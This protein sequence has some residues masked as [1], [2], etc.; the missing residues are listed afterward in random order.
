MCL[1]L[2][3]AKYLIGTAGIKNCVHI[4]LMLIM[5]VVAEGNMEIKFH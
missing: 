3:T 5:A 4:S 2:G 1:L